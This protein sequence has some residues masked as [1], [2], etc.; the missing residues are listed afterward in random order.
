M[1]WRLGEKISDVIVR[2]ITLRITKLESSKKTK[3]DR[4][5][6]VDNIS[7]VGKWRGNLNSFIKQI[8]KNKS[9]SEESDIE[10]EKVIDEYEGEEI[11]R[12]TAILTKIF[13]EMRDLKIEMKKNFIL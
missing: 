3:Q 5:S 6:K 1:S 8:Q 12:I 9:D 10:L 13:D 2:A 7:N 11:G 4:P